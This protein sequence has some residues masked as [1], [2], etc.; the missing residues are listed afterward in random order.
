ME[1]FISRVV[2]VPVLGVIVVVPQDSVFVRGTKTLSRL[3]TLS[4]RSL[5]RQ[6]PQPSDS[7][8][9]RIGV[10]VP[11][12]AERQQLID[13]LLRGFDLTRMKVVIVATSTGVAAPTEVTIVEDR[14]GINIQRWWNKGLDHLAKRGCDI[15]VVLNDD[16]RV[17]QHEV[18]SM[19]LLL[20]ESRAT[21]S[22]PGTSLRWFRRGL[23]LKWRMDG[24]LWAINL[25]HGLRP[26]ERYSWWM[27]DRDLEVRARTEFGGLLTVPVSYE[28]VPGSQT[29]S[30]S[31]L[32]ELARR[33]MSLF[34]QHHA[35]VTRTMKYMSRTLRR[36]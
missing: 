13:D 16:V 19:A 32:Q 31:D 29:A 3:V 33:D 27:G 34:G 6:L 20:A 21:I 26:D 11:T 18:E 22:S 35:A 24:A 9:A 7:S 4:T 10:V 1:S 17:S 15:A 14:E 23:P 12:S 25:H 36:P 28:H 8:S 5:T 30:R 2:W